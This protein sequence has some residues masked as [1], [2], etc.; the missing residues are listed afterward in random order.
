MPISRSEVAGKSLTV[1]EAAQAVLT[2]DPLSD[3][4][5]SLGWRTSNGQ[6]LPVLRVSS[7]STVNYTAKAKPLGTRVGTTDDTHTELLLE[8][9]REMDSERSRQW[10]GDR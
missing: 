7:K 8:L 3:V 5:I 6:R 2:A 1:T 10:A 4:R 9:A